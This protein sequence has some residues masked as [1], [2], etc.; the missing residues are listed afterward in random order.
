MTGAPAPTR[1]VPRGTFTVNIVASSVL[2]LIA[3]SAVVASVSP[4]Y[5][6]V[7]LAEERA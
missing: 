3:G 1:G 6:T 5:D 7:R 4:G 2:G